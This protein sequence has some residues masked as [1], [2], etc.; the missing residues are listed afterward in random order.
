MAG[1]Q[2]PLTSATLA[3]RRVSRKGKNEARALPRRAFH[4]QIAIHGTGKTARNIK[5][6]ARTA[7]TAAAKPFKLFKNPVLLV[8]VHARSLIGYDQARDRAFGFQ[9]K[10]DG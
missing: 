9:T 2:A 3:G 1:A 8:I 7:I 6:Q 10:P 4:R 5:P